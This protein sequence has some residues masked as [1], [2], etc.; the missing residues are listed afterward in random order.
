MLAYFKYIIK[1]KL[2]PYLLKDKFSATTQIAQVQLKQQYLEAKIKGS[3]PNFE[4]TGF[5][6]FSQFEEDGKLLYLFSI[7]GS[8]NKTFIDIG[9]NDGINS[10]CANLAVNFGWHGLFIDADKRAIAIGENFYEK[11][12]NK[13]SLKPVF[14]KAFITPENI[15]SL[16]TEEGFNGEIDLISIDIDSNDYWIWKAINCVDPKVVVIES[17]LAFGKENLIVPYKNQV[18]NASENDNYYGASTFAL[19]KLAEAKNYRLVGS[20]QYGNNLFFVKN[21]FDEI[22]LPKIDI[23]ETLKHTYA[24]KQLS[25]FEKI[26]HHQYIQE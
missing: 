22:S 12:P 4:D 16:I 19:N 25:H 2:Y 13:W 14:K 23:A 6:V 21:G 1:K 26:K 10:N 20:N 8:T 24:K 18:N 15:N 17:Q 9:S 7:L 11:I 5:K 3:L